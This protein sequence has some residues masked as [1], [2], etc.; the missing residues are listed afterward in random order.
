MS[1]SPYATLLLGIGIGVSGQL[2]LKRG[3]LQRPGFQLR[4]LLS[5]LSNSYVV[6]G[7]IC[8]GV[9]TLVYLR[10]LADLDLSLAY[11]TVGLS[12]ALIVILSQFF[13]DEKVSINRWV[14]VLIICSGVALVGLSS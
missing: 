11:P 4:D 5:L 1:F 12:Y 14:A 7:F 9:S 2:M 3:M 10:A 6:S 8:F 13:F